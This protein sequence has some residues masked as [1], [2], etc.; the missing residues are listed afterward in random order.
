MQT[1]TQ[2]APFNQTAY[3]AYGWPIN[4]ATGI[5]YNFEELVANPALPLPKHPGSV[6]R[7]RAA[8]T[9][10]AASLPRPQPARRNRRRQSSSGKVSYSAAAVLGRSPF[11]AGLRATVRRMDELSADDIPFLGEPCAPARPISAADEYGLPSAF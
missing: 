11:D 3:D 6:L 4:P 7:A 9:L 10:S 5:S 2:T 1:I 8:I